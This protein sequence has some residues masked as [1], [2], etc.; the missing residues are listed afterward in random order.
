MRTKTWHK[1]SIVLLN[2]ENFQYIIKLQKTWTL[3]T[4]FQNA[5]LGPKE[6]NPREYKSLSHFSTLM[7]AKDEPTRKS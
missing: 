7:A 4:V 6:S 5:A 2:I 1:P 3:K